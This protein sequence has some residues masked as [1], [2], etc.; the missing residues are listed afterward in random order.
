M[1]SIHGILAPEVTSY[2]HYKAAVAVRLY[3]VRSVS[4]IAVAVQLAAEALVTYARAASAE[5]VAVA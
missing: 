1:Y 5:L 3:I 4:A 2:A